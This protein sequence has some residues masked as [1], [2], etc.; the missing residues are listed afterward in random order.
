VALNPQKEEAEKQK[1]KVEVMAGSDGRSYIQREGDGKTSENEPKDYPDSSSKDNTSNQASTTAS[2]QTEQ[3]RQSIDNE[4]RFDNELARQKL[5]NI[6]DQNIEQEDFLENSHSLTD[7]LNREIITEEASVENNKDIL[8]FEF[9]WSFKEVR[10]YL[11][12]LYRTTGDSGRIWFSGRI[13]K[14]TGE[15]I[16]HFGRLYQQ[17]QEEHPDGNTGHD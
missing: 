10:N 15:V 5:D 4:D 7:T 16:S 6:N 13:N 8:P 3:E 14:N 1:T 17:L 2:Q 11:T 9:S 12:P